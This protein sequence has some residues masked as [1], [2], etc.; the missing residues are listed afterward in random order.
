MNLYCN[1]GLAS[2]TVKIT[3][4][5]RS[6]AD[7]SSPRGR[8]NP[9]SKVRKSRLRKDA[10]LEKRRTENP[11]APPVPPEEDVHVIHPTLETSSIAPDPSEDSGGKE[12]NQEQTA[13]SLSE[14]QRKNRTQTQNTDWTIDDENWEIFS[15]AK[16]LPLKLNATCPEQHKYNCTEQWPLSLFLYN[17]DFSWMETIQCPSCSTLICKKILGNKHVMLIRTCFN[18][19]F[20]M[21]DRMTAER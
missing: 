15:F 18:C 17:A 21:S 10:W 11:P 4:G 7:N 1:R 20:I 14:W 5:S 6:S 19:L 13:D 12:V 3:F 2:I 16:L 8:R 9:Y